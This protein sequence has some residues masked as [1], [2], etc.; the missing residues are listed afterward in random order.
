MEGQT[1]QTWRALCEQAVIEK[2]IDKLIQLSKEIN[3]VLTEEENRQKL[4][5][6]DAAASRARV[7]V[8]ER[9]R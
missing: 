7:R 5:A 4:P 3:R 9:R 6:V 1:Q 8:G 2:D